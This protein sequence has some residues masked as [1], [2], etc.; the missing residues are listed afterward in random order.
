MHQP[1]VHDDTPFCAAETLLILQDNVRGAGALR[2]GWSGALGAARMGV[3][4]LLG[5]SDRGGYAYKRGDPPT[6]QRRA[7]HRVPRTGA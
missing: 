4:A 7:T 5:G 3:G 2:V 6:P 1:V